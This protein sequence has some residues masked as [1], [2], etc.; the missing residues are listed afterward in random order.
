MLE[1]DCFYASIISLDKGKKIFKGKCLPNKK[2]DFNGLGSSH[3]HLENK[4]FLSIG[5]PEQ[6]SFDIRELAQKNDSVYGKIVTINK[7]DLNQVIKGWQEALQ[8]MSVGSKWEIVIPSELAYGDRG[9]GR[10]ISPNSTLL[11][12]IELISIK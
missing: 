8:L 11:F 7:N 1:D 12:D 2:I 4:I 5:A 9:A 3:V 10:V 6:E